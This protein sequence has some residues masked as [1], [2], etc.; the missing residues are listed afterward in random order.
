MGRYDCLREPAPVSIFDLFGAALPI[1][2]PAAMGAIGMT[3][4]P[5]IAMNALGCLP[6]AAQLID[7]PKA[8]KYRKQPAVRMPM[9]PAPFGWRNR[10]KLP[11]LTLEA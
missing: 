2:M 6:E 10:H 8:R 3:G 1:L 4:A 9:R 7:R 11:D 5:A